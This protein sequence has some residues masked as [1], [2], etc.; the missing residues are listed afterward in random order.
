MFMIWK[1]LSSNIFCYKYDGKKSEKKL[2]I[3]I[4]FKSLLKNLGFFVN[5]S[6]HSILYGENVCSRF[7]NYNMKKV[8]E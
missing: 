4:E 7:L 3:S 6:A 1:T 8:F 2:Q 5:S